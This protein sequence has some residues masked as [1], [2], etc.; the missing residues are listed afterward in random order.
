MGEAHLISTIQLQR[1]LVCLCSTSL[2]ALSRSSELAAKRSDLMYV[3]SNLN[4]SVVAIHGLGGHYKAAWQATGPHGSEVN[5]LKDFIPRVCTDARVMSYGY[6]SQTVFTQSVAT[7]RDQA[8]AFLNAIL[9]VRT[10]PSSSKRPIIFIAH[11]LG[12][13]IMKQVSNLSEEML[14]EF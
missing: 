10:D 8:L 6:D 12:G 3:S 13:I 5:W 7:I 9:D 14:R 2:L 11:S 1:I 4:Q